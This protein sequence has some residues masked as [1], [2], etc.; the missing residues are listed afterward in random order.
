MRCLLS[1]ALGLVLALPALAQ[2]PRPGDTVW[3]QWKP[4]G[5]FKGKVD[6]AGA[7]GLK[8]DFDDGDRGEYA[9][10]MMALDKAP[11]KGE[12]KAGARVLALFGG[13]YFPGTVTEID[14]NG[15]A[16]INF[17]DGDKGESAE[18]DLRLLAVNKNNVRVPRVDDV[19][20]AQWGPGGW[21]R[22]KVVKGGTFGT[23][24]RFDDG[25]KGEY[26]PPLIA[27][28]AA[29]KKG[30]VKK[31]HRVLVSVTQDLRTSG[32]V[33]GVGQNGKATVLLDTQE[34]VDVDEAELRLIGE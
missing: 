24:V 33:T 30:Q 14:K 2:D 4:N 13:N 16:K 7:F 15:T 23:K 31:G 18:A 9:P 1:L 25:D 3:A 12:V 32:T 17:D 27:A 5:W 8:I 26:P 19:V 11:K 20:W 29:P 34:V 21:Y 22:G 28:D 10:S 6:R